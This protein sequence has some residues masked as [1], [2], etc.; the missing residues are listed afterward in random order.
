MD[1][2]YLLIACL[3]VDVMEKSL[4]RTMK[5]LRCNLAKVGLA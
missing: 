4:D 3:S 2:H 5:K 1:K